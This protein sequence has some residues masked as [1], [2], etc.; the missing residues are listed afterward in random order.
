MRKFVLLV[1]LLLC[2]NVWA[3]NMRLRCVID[4]KIYVITFDKNEGQFAEIVMPGNSYY[5]SGTNE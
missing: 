3:E 5:A 1:G 2:S 4:T